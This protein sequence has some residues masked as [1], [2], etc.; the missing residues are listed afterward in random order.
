MNE[1]PNPSGAIADKFPKAGATASTAAA[2][3]APAPTKTTDELKKIVDAWR[4]DLVNNQVNRKSAALAE[5]TNAALDEL[6]EHATTGGDAT[7][8]D[9]WFEKHFHTP[10]V[11]H[12]TDFY[13]AL[14]V[15]KEDLKAQLAPKPQPV[16]DKADPKARSTA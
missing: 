13:N 1:Y 12:D 8:L 9:A 6:A 4:F 15:A 7:D 14:Y 3:P 5:Q 11:S 10:P 16:A 2:K